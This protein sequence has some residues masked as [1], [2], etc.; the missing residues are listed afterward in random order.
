MRLTQAQID[1]LAKEGAIR[2]E[3]N[4]RVHKH[5]AINRKDE[6]EHVQA[7]ALPEPSPPANPNDEIS[8]ALELVASAINDAQHRDIDLKQ[9]FQDI[10]STAIK[11]NEE[12][13]SALCSALTESK[14][15]KEWLFRIERNTSGV[16]TSIRATELN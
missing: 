3:D 16:M 1:A 8:R 2:E 15:P 12:I 6:P 9:T 14:K 10:F 13:K 4:R 5:S 11:S 7:E